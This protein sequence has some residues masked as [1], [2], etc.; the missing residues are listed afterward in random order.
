MNRNFARLT[1]IMKDNKIALFVSTIFLATIA[2][3]YAQAQ[4][5]LEP[6]VIVIGNTIAYHSASD[7]FIIP[8]G[9]QLQTFLFSIETVK[10]GA[11]ESRHILVRY[12]HIVGESLTKEV[13]DGK[14]DFKLNLQRRTECDAKISEYFYRGVDSFENVSVSVNLFRPLTGRAAE[15]DSVPIEKTLPCYRLLK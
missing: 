8:G 10:K 7:R 6:E 1:P 9:Y 14:S 4:R 12:Q 5:K 2:L 13:T 3:P 11:A 15:L